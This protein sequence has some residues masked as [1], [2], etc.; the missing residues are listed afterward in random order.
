MAKG[1]V[2]HALKH[3]QRQ[4]TLR[5]LRRRPRTYSELLAKVDPGGEGSGRFNY[6]LKVL[7]DA[8]LVEVDDGLY[9]PTPNGFAALQ[10]L[11]QAP[12]GTAAPP[13][14]RVRLAIV[15]S[16][17]GVGVIG[18]LLLLS[19]VLAPVVIEAPETLRNPD[20]NIPVFVSEL[21]KEAGSP[22]VAVDPDGNAIAIWT[23]DDG[24]RFNLLANRFEAGVGWG[25]PT[26]IERDDSGDA[27]APM[28]A[29]DPAGNAWAVWQQIVGPPG[30]EASPI[31][32][33][34]HNIWGNRFVPE[35]GW[36]EGRLIKSEALVGD[37]GLD[38]SGT[39]TILWTVD[40]AIYADRFVPD[41]G[42]AGAKPILEDVEPGSS[43]QL[44][45]DAEGRAIAVWAER[46]VAPPTLEIYASRYVP[47][48]GWGPAILVWA[49]TDFGARF[50]QRDILSIVMDSEG[51]AIA[52]WS[53]DIFYT[54]EVYG[55]N[56]VIYA[57]RFVP[58]FG[59]SEAVPVGQEDDRGQYA[60]KRIPPQLASD[61][62]GNAIA[63]WSKLDQNRSADLFAS[64]F[65]IGV[66]WS[67][68]IRIAEEVGQQIWD[69][70][71]ANFA[72]AIEPGGK[73]AVLYDDGNSGIFATRYL[74]GEG[75]SIP[76]L[77]GTGGTQ[78]HPCPPAVAIGPEGNVTAIWEDRESAPFGVLASRF[79]EPA[80]LEKLA[81]ET[82]DQLERNQMALEVAF[83]RIE[84]M[85]AWLAVSL[86]LL[87]ALF[88]VF[89]VLF[90]VYW[91]PRRGLAAY[92]KIPDDSGKPPGPGG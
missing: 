14:R 58:G 13:R 44:A 43:V 92:R 57:A 19:V 29:I 15:G 37:I 61:A 33:A 12:E 53:V 26:L 74:P 46:S 39:L 32:L 72:L 75:W 87:V 38:A 50:I 70:N 67:E 68:S 71:T 30:S 76:T 42:W 89:G 47:N 27:R 2:F 22:Q 83:A 35:T 24:G 4:K 90:V 28:L 21:G 59:W 17:I 78:C 88:V 69:T 1:D 65:D 31:S 16:V 7:K 11:A 84:M 66:G 5:T 52:L 23:Q 41:I 80:S 8:G 79:R 18:L 62:E 45:V 64:R 85:T 34:G 60:L 73:A 36:G 3:A 9:R 77:I 49:D 51:S 25:A 10:L 91:N 56:G 81:R 40:R 54:G 82:R 63:V 86:S 6:H 48:E 55:A 20:W